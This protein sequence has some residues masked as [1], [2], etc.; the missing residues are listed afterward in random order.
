[1]TISNDENC[2]TEENIDKM[3]E[4]LKNTNI[5]HTKYSPNFIQK[6]Q[7]RNPFSPE[8]VGYIGIYDISDEYEHIS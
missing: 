2:L 6:L 3:L 4:L 5:L 7:K 1:M 8:F